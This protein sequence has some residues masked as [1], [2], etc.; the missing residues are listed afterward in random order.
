[1]PN[2]TLPQ[3]RCEAASIDCAAIS[4]KG[5]WSTWA[6]GRPSALSRKPSLQVPRMPSVSHTLVRSSVIW[7]ASSATSTWSEVAASLWRRAVAR[8]RSACAP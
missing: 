3:S 1:M 6:T 8:I 5:F 4:A 7:S 2:H